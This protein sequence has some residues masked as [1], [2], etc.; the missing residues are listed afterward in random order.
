[1]LFTIEKCISNKFPL[2]YLVT[3]LP[4]L[5]SGGKDIRNV[6]IG[7]GG[8]F[9]VISFSKFMNYRITSWKFCEHFFVYNFLFD[10]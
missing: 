1:M 7:L 6:F 2:G 10:K 9:N 3:N 8:V 4:I 5:Q